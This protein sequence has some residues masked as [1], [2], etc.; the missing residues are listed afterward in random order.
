MAALAGSS[1]R[2]AR[3]LDRGPGGAHVTLVSRG[4]CRTRFEPLA[5]L[6]STEG[7]LHLER[8]PEFQ[9]ITL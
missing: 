8:N 5:A 7:A 6:G 3:P 4:I 1:Q 9:A 2:V